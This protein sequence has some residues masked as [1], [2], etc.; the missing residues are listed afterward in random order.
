[1]L[2][3]L[4]KLI[5]IFILCAVIFFS[6]IFAANNNIEHKT[7]KDFLSLTSKTEILIDEIQYHKTTDMSTINFGEKIAVG[8]KEL[9][10]MFLERAVI[11]KG[12][13]TN[14][15]FDYENV[16]ITGRIVNGRKSLDFSYN[17]AGFGRI[18]FNKKDWIIYGD[19]SKKIPE[20]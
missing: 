6:N 14:Y 2:K 10:K 3:Y 4:N 8:T 18:F 13:E 19:M 17:L 7:I 12:E 15:I 16:E 5:Y 9:K 20:Q 1:M 11:I